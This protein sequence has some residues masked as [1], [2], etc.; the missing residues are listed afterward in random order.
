MRT[1]FASTNILISL[2]TFPSFPQYVASIVSM[3]RLHTLLPTNQPLLKD[4]MA[5]LTAV[6]VCFQYLYMSPGILIVGVQV[7]HHSCIPSCV[8]S[9]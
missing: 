9:P 7:L 6:S 4:S 5:T 2:Y 8:E 1:N 3:Y